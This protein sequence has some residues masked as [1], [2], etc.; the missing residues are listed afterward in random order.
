MS[1]LA[2]RLDRLKRDAAERERV[3]LLE[4]PRVYV[5]GADGRPHAGPF[6]GEPQVIGGTEASQRSAVDAWYREH[7]LTKP[8]VRAKVGPGSARTRKS[9]RRIVRTSRPS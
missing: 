9:T 6:V 4:P 5:L 1:R 3:I 8:S 7:G 2:D